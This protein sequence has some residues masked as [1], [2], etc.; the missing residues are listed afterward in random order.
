MKTVDI[1]DIS[2]ISDTVK[3]ANKVLKIT[4]KSL[5][6]LLETSYYDWYH[7]CATKIIQ[8]NQILRMV[9]NQPFFINRD[10]LV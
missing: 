8:I 5:A 6:M 7:F 9:E 10:Y 4:R 1:R 3:H 2:A